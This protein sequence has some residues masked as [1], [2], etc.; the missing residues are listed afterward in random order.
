[1]LL[2]TGDQRAQIALVIFSRRFLPFGIGS[3]VPR[4]QD[5]ASARASIAAGH[6]CGAR[7]RR[8]SFEAFVQQGI[9]A[10]GRD[11]DHHQPRFEQLFLTRN[12]VW[13]RRILAVGAV[14][15]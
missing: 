15:L 12:W 14:C 13:S 7:A 4:A 3:Q 10:V 1:M 11:T 2:E 8:I 6:H 5:P 9:H